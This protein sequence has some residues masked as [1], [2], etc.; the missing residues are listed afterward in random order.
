MAIKTARL[1]EATPLP[2]LCALRSARRTLERCFTAD[3]RIQS[4]ASAFGI[5]GGTNGT[6][7]SFSAI[8]SIFS[9]RIIP[10]I[11]HAHSLVHYRRYI[12]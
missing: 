8:T 5:C 4:V 10:L 12:I 3:A 9:C 11:L 2:F 1:T 7:T 6:G